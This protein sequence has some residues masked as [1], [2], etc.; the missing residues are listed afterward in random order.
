[1]YR[2]FKKGLFGFILAFL[3]L[4]FAFAAS[5]PVPM[6]QQTADNLIQQLKANRAQFKQ[7]PQMVYDIVQRLVLPHVD[8]N[9]MARSV[10]DNTL[11][12]QA[13]ASDRAQFISQF[14]RLVLRT[15][16][17]AF[18]EYTNEIVKFR[19]IRSD[20]AQQANLTIQ[21]QII[22]GG[23]SPIPVDYSVARQG[24]SWKIY[25][26]TVDGISMVNSFRSQ[27]AGLNKGSLAQINQFL[28][29]RNSGKR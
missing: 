11:W 14:Q 8:K 6:L 18:A 2:Y 17:A 24:A 5:S 26:F 3:T 7:N 12:Q 9:R 13:S 16:A 28:A 29:Q 22:R 15:Y 19:P 20:Y 4:N 25:D 21:S 10:V 1:M 27:F 23:K